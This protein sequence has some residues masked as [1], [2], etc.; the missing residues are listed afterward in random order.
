M[1]RP[2]QRCLEG[3]SRRRAR[4][5]AI[6]LLVIALLPGSCAERHARPDGVRRDEPPI[7]AQPSRILDQY[8]NATSTAERVSI[9]ES[10]T[11]STPESRRVLV[12]AFDSDD[13]DV[14]PAAVH[15]ICRR[16][17]GY[18]PPGGSETQ[19]RCAETWLDANAR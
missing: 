15:T 4:P 19:I 5:G 7:E 11:E 16:F 3:S 12:L 2:T 17:A 1:T 8:L 18:V 9:V 14:T 13:P 6:A 10:I